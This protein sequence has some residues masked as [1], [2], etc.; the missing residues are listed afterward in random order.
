MLKGLARDS[1]LP[2][3]V[4]GDFNDMLYED[5]KR[6]GR[7]QPYNLLV[8]FMETLNAC[9]F[10]DLGYVGEKYTWEKSRGQ[11][12]WIQEIL[13]RGVANQG[14]QDLFPSAL[15]RV[16][17][18]ATS[19]YLPLF[20]QLHKQVNVAKERRFRFEN[21]WVREKECR[22]IV[23]NRWEGSGERDIIEKIRIC[24]VKLREWG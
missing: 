23:K 16:M 8:G 20:L 15:I 12:N 1:G 17:E 10:Q 18:V 4:V 3:C 13:Y 6:G 24:G 9:G 2:W 19:D 21:V 11:P 5:E 14:W 22:N 7:K